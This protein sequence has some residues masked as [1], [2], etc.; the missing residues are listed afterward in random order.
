MIIPEQTPFGIGVVLHEISQDPEIAVR[1][2]LD[3]GLTSVEIS[4]IDGVD[5][6]KCDDVTVDRTARLLDDAGMPVIGI[7]LGL[8]KSIV[9]GESDGGIFDRADYRAE[10]ARL[11]RAIE[12]ADRFTGPEGGRVPWLRT[13]SFRRTESPDGHPYPRRPGGGP[14]PDST[15]G[16]IAEGLGPAVERASAAGLR[17]LIENVRS[18]WGNSGANTAAIARRLATPAVGI[19]WDPANAWVSGEQYPAGWDAAEPYVGHVHVKDAAL[20]QG[21]ADE[22]RWECIGRGDAMMQDELRALWRHPWRGAVH[23]E[24]HWKPDSGENGTPATHAGL[25][26]IL[27]EIASE[28]VQ[29]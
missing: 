15:L 28:E 14:L 13:F 17:L 9:L 18:C 26:R 7:S 4:S 19:I 20:E 12:L 11:D 5:L 21:S 8:F 24:T 22:T 29:P 25:A 23:I 2:A 1:V 16:A 27:N 6:D 3:L 10:V